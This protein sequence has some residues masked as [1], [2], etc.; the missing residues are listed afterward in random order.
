MTLFRVIGGGRAGLSFVSALQR[1]GWVCSNIYG[2]TDDISEAAVGV[3]VVLVAVPDHSIALVARAINPADAAIV[4]VSGA[5]KLD[6]LLPHQDRGSVHPLVSLPDP[7]I[8]ADRLLDGGTFAVAG[9]PVALDVVNALGGRA[10]E[11]NDEHR[12]LYHASAAIAAN[13]LVA[14]CAQVERV[15]TALEI[16]VEPL[17]NLMAT[18]LDN[19]RDIGAVAALTGPAAR[20]DTSTIDAHLSV[21]PESEHQLYM[22]LAREAARLAGR[23]P[24]P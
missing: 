7:T 1:S 18:T 23:E 15:A 19:I 11:I 17:W 16:P 4:H 2:P 6:A 24:Y 13:H 3:D 9:H 22:S 14:L 10:I 5:T 8:G 21:L 12:V 20:G